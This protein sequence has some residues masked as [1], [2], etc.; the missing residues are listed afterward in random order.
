MKP[1]NCKDAGDVK[2]LNENGIAFNDES[3]VVIPNYVVLKM[4]HTQIQIGMNRFKQFAE[5]YLTDQ[6][7]EE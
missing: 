4:G 3:I 7:K 2:K 5:W 6:R 1:C